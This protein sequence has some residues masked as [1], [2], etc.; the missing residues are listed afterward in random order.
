[1]AYTVAAG[2]RGAALAGVL[3]ACGACVGVAE[4]TPDP[5]ASCERE[6]DVAL[7]AAPAHL[8]QARNPWY[9]D[10]RRNL[11]AAQARR[12]LPG[13][14]RNVIVFVGDGMDPNTVTA[15]RIL[16]GQSLGGCGEEHTLSF[17]RFPYT[18]VVKTYSTDAQTAD[19]AATSTALFSGVKTRSGVIGLDDRVARGDCA[20][21]RGHQTASLFEL[22]EQA[23][24]ATGI[25]TTARVTHAT[26]AAA[27]AHTPE[28]A[29]EH[30]A[31]IPPAARDAGCADIA[32]QLVEFPHGDGIDLVLG[33]GRR[34]FLHATQPDPE[35]GSALQPWQQ[36]EERSDTGR[37]E[38]GRDL[39]AEWRERYPA[40]R[41]VWNLAGF[42]ALTPTW[43][44]PV[45]GLFDASHM[46]YEADRTGAMA[47]EPSLSAMTA[48]AIDILA[49][50]P[51]GFVLLVEGGRIDHAHH[52]GNAARALAETIEFARAVGVAA[53]R[54][55]ELDT[56]ILVT[57]DH[58][59]TLSLT[60][61]PRRGN[62]V[63]GLVVDQKT[64]RFAVDQ[65]GERYTMLVY[66]NGPGAQR[67]ARRRPDDTDPEALDHRQQA[68]VPLAD[69]THG[70][71]D[72]L[73][74]ARGPLAHLVQGVI[75]Q[76]Y[77]FHVAAAAVNIGDPAGT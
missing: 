4:R 23:G 67:D 66:A 75:E 70:G 73:V 54:T 62:A 51:R 76:N 36:E 1:M 48:K 14:A 43:E 15:A 69:E 7:A 6:H 50:R 22:A 11:E 28:R 56:L 24:L 42:E 46:D 65:H 26:P 61:Y 59:H 74:Y 31:E 40:G 27:F 33:G 58:G 55:D 18:G 68:L 25:V 9:V 45:L 5:I 29:W 57:A 17:E 49:G 10:A 53:E 77:L 38:D 20:A 8:P 2:V 60:G 13:P 52:A 3:I 35:A 47:G 32:A 37:R 19:S 64:G 16:E 21:T 72:V 34:A 44:T 30:D 41:Y 63:L 71:N 12:P 39:I